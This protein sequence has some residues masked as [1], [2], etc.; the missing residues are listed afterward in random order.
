M[1]AIPTATA[2][3]SANFFIVAPLLSFAFGE[4]RSPACGD[5]PQRGARWVPRF[6][7]CRGGAFAAQF[8]QT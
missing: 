6:A 8:Q 2:M 1:A 7:A 4:K 5:S 3:A